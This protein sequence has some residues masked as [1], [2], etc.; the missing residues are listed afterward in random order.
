MERRE[1]VAGAG[2]LLANGHLPHEGSADD[3]AAVRKTVADVYAAYSGF[4][5]QKYRAL[6]TGDYLLLEDGK[7]LDIDGDVAMMATPDSAHQRTDVFDFRFV[8]VQDDVAYAVYFLKSEIRDPKGTRNRE[9]LESAILR[10]AGTGWRM[11]L[12]HSTRITK[13]GG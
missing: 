7:L 3:A 1:F 5:Q 9:W 12:L 4:D 2:V 11:A 6:L 8:K 13:P 10:R